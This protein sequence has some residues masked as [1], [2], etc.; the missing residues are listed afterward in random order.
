MT[1][2][3]IR[4]PCLVKLAYKLLSLDETRKVTAGE[5][6]V[7]VRPHPCWNPPD[8][9]RLSSIDCCGNQSKLFELQPSEHEFFTTNSKGFHTL[10]SDWRNVQ[11]AVMAE[12]ACDTLKIR[13]EAKLGYPILPRW[14]IHWLEDILYEG[15]LSLHM[16]CKAPE[17]PVAIE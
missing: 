12:H 16:L 8:R 6:G 13:I 1:T 7:Y 9:L 4:R 3:R 14:S 15:S 11:K 10:L 2:L 5:W 17:G